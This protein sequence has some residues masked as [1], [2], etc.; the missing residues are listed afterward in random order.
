MRQ[1]PK[2]PP[3][4]SRDAAARRF[5]C[6]SSLGRIRTNDGNHPFAVEAVAVPD[7]QPTAD[8]ADAGAGRSIGP[9]LLCS[10]A[11]ISSL[12]SWSS[13]LSF[14]RTGSDTRTQKIY[15]SSFAPNMRMAK[16]SLLA[17]VATAVAIAIVV[18]VI[19]AASA[20]S[21]ANYTTESYNVL[22][23]Q[24]KGVIAGADGPVKAKVS[25]LLTLS[26]QFNLVEGDGYSAGTVTATT[27]ATGRVAKLVRLHQTC[28]ISYNATT[29]TF[30]RRVRCRTASRG[31]RAL[32]A[33]AGLDDPFDAANLSA[34]LDDEASGWV[35]GVD[36][37]EVGNSRR[38]RRRLS[39]CTT[40]IAA[41][42]TTFSTRLGAVCGSSFAGLVP[43]RYPW[44][45]AAA[46][47][48]CRLKNSRQL[49][50]PRTVAYKACRCSCDIN[51]DCPEHT[52]DGTPCD[53]VCS[54][55]VCLVQPGQR[56]GGGRTCAAPADATCRAPA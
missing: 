37:V 19:P 8:S 50:K 33:N 51:A 36:P 46:L 18:V 23:S 54:E 20:Q 28:A 31:T 30:V 3:R 11:P 17:S 32:T 24:A 7:R 15:Y 1:P 48:L 53:G 47:V 16:L 4:F 39:D 21:V 25:A 29:G 35:E 52:C 22:L 38:V 5:L 42:S 55:G 56:T 27:D 41:V 2:A 6:G 40:C 12:A 14:R 13:S 43:A 49:G 9:P 10:T 44:A 26:L 34:Q 45:K